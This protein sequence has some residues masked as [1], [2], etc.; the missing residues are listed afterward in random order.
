MVLLL[1]LDDE[2][3]DPHA[4]PNEPAGFLL[5]Q[6]RPIPRDQ[7]IP[8]AVATEGYENNKIITEENAPFNSNQSNGLAAAVACYPYVNPSPSVPP[9]I[10]LSY[11]TSAPLS[12]ILLLASSIDLNTLHALSL[13]CRQIRYNLLQYRTRLLQSTLRCENE[14]QAH[15]LGLAALKPEGQKWHILGEA[16]HLV[17]GKVGTCARDLVGGCRRCG[18]VVCRV[19]CPPNFFFSRPFLDSFLHF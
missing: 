10:A 6:R 7:K 12:I 5:R 4:D 1:D 9:S 19:C 3:P 17:S 8:A 11:L 15:H 13:T 14:A 16:G 2:V 18:R